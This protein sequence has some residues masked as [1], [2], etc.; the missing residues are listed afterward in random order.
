ML[1]RKQDWDTVHLHQY[2]K[3][4]QPFEW[5]KA[6]CCLFAANAIE[7]QT[8]IDIA[9]DFRGQY[10]DKLSAFAL[11]RKVTGGSTVAVAA[12]YCA[13]KHGL[14]EL[15]YPLMAQRGDLVVFKNVDDELIAGIVHLSGRH[16]VSVGET[17]AVKVDITN[18]VRAWSI[19][20]HAHPLAFKE[21]V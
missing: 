6:D 9:D 19:S 3:N 16:L 21:G 20:G 7:A 10:T 8:G 18:V 15:Q 1:T 11:I 4:A 2:L 12:A 14:K 13:K 5:G 17:G